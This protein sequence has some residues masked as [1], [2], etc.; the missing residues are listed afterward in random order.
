MVFYLTYFSHDIEK[1]HNLITEFFTVV[2]KK[3][4]N[5][6]NLNL[7]P[8]WYLETENRMLQMEEQL[9]RF[10]KFDE[11]IKIE[12]IEAF[13][14]CQDIEYVF[15]CDQASF[16]HHP[17]AFDFRR[18][19]SDGKIDTTIEEFLNFLFVETLYN[20]QLSKKDS[21][22]SKKI[23]SNIGSH[24]LGMKAQQSFF[25][26]DVT[27]CPFCGIEPLKLIESE[28]RPDYDHL[29]PKGNSLYVFN[30]INIKNLIPIGDHCNSKK[31]SKNLIFSDDE[32]KVKCLAFYP[33][34]SPPNPYELYNINLSCTELPSDVNQ[35]KG[36]WNI[37]ILPID[38]NDLVTQAKIQTWDRIF[39]IKNR[40]CEFIKEHL[41]PL[42]SKILK[43]I[44]TSILDLLNEVKSK[45]KGRLDDHYK[46]DYLF[47]ST[48]EGLIPMRNLILW[49][50][51]NENFLMSYIE[52]KKKVDVYD[53]DMS[54]MEF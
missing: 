8:A 12:I 3:D 9:T 1:L 53:I 46:I 11:S 29:L 33:Y 35:W 6:F 50:L 51:S 18:T 22:F 42:I 45:L 4:I 32:R 38:S 21:T 40:Y 28:A 34:S 54:M 31:S 5:T 30:A 13:L 52:Q 41:K 10:L 49:F 23:H 17:I 47:I 19:I 48:E 16:V 14:K 36:E 44:D 37:D 2:Y 27:L 39:N 7:L 20:N 15:G 26:Q 43:T 25:D 24:Y